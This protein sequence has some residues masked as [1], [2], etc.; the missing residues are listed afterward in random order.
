MEDTEPVITFIAKNLAKTGFKFQHI[1]DSDR[2]KT[3]KMYQV[4]IQ[5]LEAE[6]IYEVTEVLENEFEC[7][8]HEEQIKVVRVKETEKEVGIPTN[9]TFSGATISFNP[10]DCTETCE[11]NKFCV[12]AG[13]KKGDKVRILDIIQ[14]VECGE[15]NEISITLVARIPQA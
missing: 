4:C 8:L 9:I 7:P 12:P 1:G 11:F 3:C 13:L 6:R 5:P 15:G 10:Q 14:K 2:C